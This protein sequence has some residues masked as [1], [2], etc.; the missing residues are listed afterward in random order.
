MTCCD[1]HVQ[2][3][4][5]ELQSC[6]ITV[7]VTG[8]FLDRLLVPRC[9]SAWTL[10]RLRGSLRLGWILAGDVFSSENSQPKQRTSILYY[11]FVSVTSP[12]KHLYRTYQSTA[13]FSSFRFGS[14]IL[15][16][17]QKL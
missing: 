8:L 4:V 14:L 6:I 1:L 16:T 17:S 11:G 12:T 15:S 7:V 10:S 3:L 2:G 5:A 9:Y 13:I